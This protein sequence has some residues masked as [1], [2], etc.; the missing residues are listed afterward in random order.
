MGHLGVGKG[1]GGGGN[2][3]VGGGGSV[4]WDVEGV[5]WEW[6]ECGARWVWGEWEWAEGRVE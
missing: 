6:S 4:I 2:G 3:G 1:V 5:V